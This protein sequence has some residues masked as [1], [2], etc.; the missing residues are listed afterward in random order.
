[1]IVFAL[2]VV[3]ARATPARKP[4]KEEDFDGQVDVYDAESLSE[5]IAPTD[6]PDEPGG[7]SSKNKRIAII[8][9][10]VC[11]VVVIAAIVVIICI[12]KRRK[13]AND[14]IRQTLGMQV[15]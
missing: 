6:V 13:D 8:V 4:E 7:S 9:G 1:M 14:P 2:V 11:A 5:S 15:V 3:L 12:C 10:I